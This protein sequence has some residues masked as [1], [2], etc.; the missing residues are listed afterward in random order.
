LGC[1]AKQWNEVEENVLMD[2]EEDQEEVEETEE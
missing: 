2:Q 1:K